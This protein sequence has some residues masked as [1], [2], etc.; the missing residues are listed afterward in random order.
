MKQP[1]TTYRDISPLIAADLRRGNAVRFMAQGSSME[2]FLKAGDFVV[3]E[4]FNSTCRCV[5][6][7]RGA[8]M[9]YELPSGAHRLHRF[10]RTV[11]GD[12]G[13]TL[14]RFRGD[15]PGHPAE[16]IKPEQVLGTLV[17]CERDGCI[18]NVDNFVSRQFGLYA[19]KLRNRLQHKK[20]NVAQ[21]ESD[22]TISIITE[23]LRETLRV[24]QPSPK[25]IPA[26]P[27]L[28]HTALRQGV[29]AICA[30]ALLSKCPGAGQD[31][32]VLARSQ[33]FEAE[34]NRKFIAEA[35]RALSAAGI[36]PLIVKGPAIG[37]LAYS[38]PALRPYDDVDLLLSGEDRRRAP[39][40]LESL[41]WRDARN[42]PAPARTHLLRT[43][44]DIAFHHPDCSVS[45]DIVH[46]G[47]ILCDASP[48]SGERVEFEIHGAIAFAPSKSE[49]FL[50]CAAHGAKHGFSRLVWLADL[51]RL[52]STFTPS[53]WTEVVTMAKERHLTRALALACAMAEELL[54]MPQPPEAQGCWRGSAWLWG[55]V[56]ACR[57][58][59]PRISETWRWWPRLLD[60][61]WQRMRHFGR[62]LFV[63]TGADLRTCLLPLWAHGAYFLLRPLRLLFRLV[64]RTGTPEL[65]WPDELKTDVKKNGEP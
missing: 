31:I 8:V 9:L 3:V 54:G 64:L 1:E 5:A 45:I 56:T 40:V 59:G 63:P 24:E 41:G 62:W 52:A 46:P 48:R 51:D 34:N 32:R 18:T 43:T 2:P 35:I 50:Y 13:S 10:T 60:T 42:C 28:A 14:F 22:D 25:V 53:D 12:N 47:G 17:A 39:A 57:E 49:H 27:R 7:P 61:S 11:R 21:R 36:D 16:L 4:P 37:A 15:T 26:P 19:S 20:T 44:E 29:L 23:T 38:S 6:P 58:H 65:K 30:E 33:A 55:K